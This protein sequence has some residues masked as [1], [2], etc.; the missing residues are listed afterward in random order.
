MF[1]ILK[2]RQERINMKILILVQENGKISTQIAY[3]LNGDIRL[4]I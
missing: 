2:L 4:S 1:G 3:I